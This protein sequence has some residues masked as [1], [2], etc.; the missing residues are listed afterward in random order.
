MSPFTMYMTSSLGSTWN[1]L[2]PARPRA[3]KA[4]VSA[5]C[6]RMRTGFGEAT[7]AAMTSARLIELRFSIRGS[8]TSHLAQAR[9]QPIAEPV[10]EEVEG[11]HHEQDGQP[12]HHR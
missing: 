8:S 5:V 7:I 12:R 1:S 9:V 3:T 4:T 10:A 2:L 6:H 11:E